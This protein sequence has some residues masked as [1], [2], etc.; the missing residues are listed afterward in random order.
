MRP[1]SLFR[2]ARSA[3]EPV[4]PLAYGRPGH[5]LAE[6]SW[7]PAA[8]ELD[9]TGKQVLVTGA[10][11]GIGLATTRALAARG[12]QVWMLCRSLDRG[13]AARQEILAAM[14]EARLRLEQVDL[15]EFASVRALVERLD[16]ERVDVLVHNAG[17][18][19]D[20]LHRTADGHELTLATNLLGPFLLT[21]LLLPRLHRGRVIL[22]SSGGMYSQ[23]LELAPLATPEVPFD[24]VV[25]YARTKRALVVL[26]D[27][28]SQRHPEVLF[29]SMHPGWADTPAVRNSLPRFHRITRSFLRN[30]E[31]GADTVVWLA[32][33]P[34]LQ[35][36]SGRF[37]FDRQPRR[38]H[39]LP[40]TRA[41]GEEREALLPWCRERVG[42]A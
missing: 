9:M 38:T 32:M 7:D 13:E 39:I 23:R 33:T 22:V 31:Q 18:L 27:L 19:P 3:L 36:H 17:V 5:L 16:L 10:N 14:P 21:E 11:S 24:G 12:A 25:A 37:W 26:A 20:R 15:S 30:P 28:W 29:A 41:D 2:L 35:G 4:V 40:G 34:A 1:R 42:L 8:L 6:A